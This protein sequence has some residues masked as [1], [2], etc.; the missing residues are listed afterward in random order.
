MTLARIERISLIGTFQALAVL[1]LA[2]LPGAL[3]VW[4]FEREA[5]GFGTQA[6]QR[7]KLPPVLDGDD[8]AGHDRNDQPGTRGEATDDR[9]PDGRDFARRSGHS[10]ALPRWPT[11]ARVRPGAPARRLNLAWP[12]GVLGPREGRREEKHHAQGADQR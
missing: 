12:W 11:V 6:E 5:G 4:A 2:L 3:Y 7:K 8:Q 10:L 1:L 9:R